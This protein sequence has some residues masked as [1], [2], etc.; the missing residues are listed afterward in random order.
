[1]D[2]KCKGRG[3][4]RDISK[5]IS[6]SNSS[7]YESLLRNQHVLLRISKGYLEWDEYANQ[8]D[9][10]SNECYAKVDSIHQP[11]SVSRSLS[12]TSDVL[13]AADVVYDRSVIPPLIS[14]V[15]QHLKNPSKIAIFATTFRNAK[16]FALFEKEIQSKGITVQFASPEDLNKM[17]FIFP[18]YIS[19]PRSDVRISFMTVGT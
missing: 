8:C 11:D 1:M 15:R 17:P 5:Y 12:R 7:L 18:C 19:Q 13:I 3:L 10:D 14:V 2:S 9:E 4:R 16:T 6:C